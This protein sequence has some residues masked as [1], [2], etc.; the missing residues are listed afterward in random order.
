ME[1]L[2]FVIKQAKIDALSGTKRAITIKSSSRYPLMSSD[3]EDFRPL[4]GGKFGGVRTDFPIATLSLN[5]GL[6]RV[7]YKSLYSI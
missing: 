6:S 1:S 3:V 2:L 7:W 4:F 5:S